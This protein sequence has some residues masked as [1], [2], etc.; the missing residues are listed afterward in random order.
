MPIDQAAGAK[1]AARI[2]VAPERVRLRTERSEAGARDLTILPARG[3][4]PGPTVI[5][6]HGLGMR[7]EVF[8]RWLQGLYDTP[9]TWILP[10]GPYPFEGRFSGLQSIGH[11]WY[12][13]DGNTPAFRA[14]LRESE[15]RVLELLDD[16]AASG[17]LDP[18]RTAVVGF[19]QGAFF[20]GSLALRHTER[21]CA[22]ACVAGR[23]RPGYAAR[24]IST[25]P[26]LPIL[27]LHGRDDDVVEVG[28]ARASAGELEAHGFPVRFVEVGGGHMWSAEMSNALRGF[29]RARLGARDSGTAGERVRPGGSSNPSSGSS[30]RTTI[31]EP[32]GS[33]TCWD[34]A[35]DPA[36][37]EQ[38]RPDRLAV[39][40]L[41][42]HRF[43]IWTTSF[44]VYH[45]D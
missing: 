8:A 21:F 35:G 4:S 10:E 12:L 26:R 39:R 19:S 23:I 38:A 44:L 37:E 18:G 9:W 32:P 11:A 17:V 2:G 22:L 42:G 7:I 31:R 30:S 45:G 29:L 25:I 27:Y 16:R 33:A 24:E 20:A 28:R 13:W 1:L 5:A 36:Y 40:H 43:H 34:S 14:S 3:G 41:T 15:A 6:F